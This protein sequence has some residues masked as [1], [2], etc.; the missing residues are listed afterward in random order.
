MSEK[1]RFRYRMNFVKIPYHPRWIFMAVTALALLC[2]TACAVPDR[3]MENRVT[4]QV[5]ELD[6]LATRY[7][8]EGR[9]DDAILYAE[10]IVE[11]VE[12]AVGSDDV[13]L[14]QPLNN[15][16][17]LYEKAGR[18]NQAETQYQRVLAILNEKLGPEHVRTSLNQARLGAFYL[19]QEKPDRAQTLYEESLKNLEQRLN[20]DHPLLSEPLAGLAGV[21]L[22]LNKPDEARK[23]L[24]RSR[25]ILEKAGPK[26]KLRLAATLQNL[27][28]IK[29]RLKD[30]SE[31]ASLLKQAITIIDKTLGSDHAMARDARKRLAE[32]S[33]Y[34]GDTAGAVDH[35][36]RSLECAQH[37]MERAAAV[38]TTESR[39]AFVHS[40]QNDFNL[41]LQLIL[42]KRTVNPGD[43]AQAYSLWLTCKDLNLKIQPAFQAAFLR[44]NCDKHMEIYRTFVD[45][46]LELA[47]TDMAVPGPEEIS[48]Y[49]KSRDRLIQQRD[50]LENNLKTACPVFANQMAQDTAQAKQVIDAL[51]PDEILVEFVR[52]RSVELNNQDGTGKTLPERYAAFVVLTEGIDLVDLGPSETIESYLLENKGKP[53]KPSFKD[54]LLNPLKPAMSGKTKIFIAPQGPLNNVPFEILLGQNAAVQVIPSGSVLIGKNTV[55]SGSGPDLYFIDPDF[56]ASS[57]TIAQVLQRLNIPSPI[58]PDGKR[59]Q[60][61]W[62]FQIPPIPESDDQF[63][64]EKTNASNAIVYRNET[65]LEDILRSQ[66]NPP[67]T[68]VIQTRCLG[69]SSGST[70]GN[71]LRDY[72]LAMAGANHTLADPDLTHSRNIL[73]AEEIVLTNL[74]GTNVIFISDCFADRSGNTTRILRRAFFRAGALTV[75]FLSF[76]SQTN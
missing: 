66:K 4:A 16:A 5:R 28:G 34:Q 14:A 35:L 72:A 1:D 31:A 50:T 39:N 47:R 36:A 58:Q 12:S 13:H 18:I 52:L 23:M 19:R 46:A 44:K 15:L 38:F 27:S 24:E 69:E 56:N 6:R 53:Q 68:L 57:K 11:R 30:Y 8:R 7:Y 48:G 43:A 33:L 20:P 25:T 67:Q 60:G 17:V 32:I 73:T 70:N 42:N 3:T 9:L 61:M 21:M 62:G 65:A 63:I 59:G 49:K 74:T 64:N 54:F 76:A 37:P 45:A 40:M 71:P 75:R 2:L 29:V 22:A 26:E 41:Y 55:H 51:G 10:E